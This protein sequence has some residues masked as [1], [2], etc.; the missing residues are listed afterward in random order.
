MRII[1]SLRV[2][3]RRYRR[4]RGRYAAKPGQRRYGG[5][6]RG[7]RQVTRHSG[8]GIEAV[9]GAALATGAERAAAA[10]APCAALTVGRLNVGC[11]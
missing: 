10:Q 4:A 8:A 7:R 2:N 6:G 9:D 3:Q 11:L 5:E 1:V